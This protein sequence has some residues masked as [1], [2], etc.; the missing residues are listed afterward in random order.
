MAVMDAIKLQMECLGLNLLPWELVIGRARLITSKLAAKLNWGVK[1]SDTDMQIICDV[2]E[3]RS[4][5]DSGHG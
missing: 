2:Q 1:R 5:H 3:G 4:P